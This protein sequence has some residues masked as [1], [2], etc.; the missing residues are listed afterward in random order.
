MWKKCF[1]ESE[2]YY[3]A[4]QI[5]NERKLTIGSVTLDYDSLTVTR[6]GESQTLPPK[7]ILFTL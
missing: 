5:V 3:V 4:H 2:R 7:R 6:E 1:C